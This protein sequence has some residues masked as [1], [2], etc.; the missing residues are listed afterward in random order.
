MGLDG[1]TIVHKALVP[2]NDLLPPSSPWGLQ[3]FSFFAQIDI[4]FIC[5]FYLSP[6]KSSNRC[7]GT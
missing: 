3:R 1:G 7:V 2:E 6:M 5:S 4:L